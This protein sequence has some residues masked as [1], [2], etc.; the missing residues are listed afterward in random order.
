MNCKIDRFDVNYVGNMGYVKDHKENYTALTVD[1]KN[2][3][4]FNYLFAK[5]GKQIIEEYLQGKIEIK[6]DRTLYQ[7]LRDKLCL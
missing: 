7:K 4:R 3:T 2:D 5:A 6:D 1:L